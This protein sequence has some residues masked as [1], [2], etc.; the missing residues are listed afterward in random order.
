MAATETARPGQTTGR[1]AVG[2]RIPVLFIAGAARSGSTL[3]ERAIGVHDG[4]CS[5]GELQFIWQRSFGENQL[6]GCGAPFH[7][8]D[9]WRAVSY[10]AF[11][12]EPAEVDELAA[13]RLKHEVD[14]KRR[15]PSLVL[16]PP[17]R[18][19]QA[20]GAYG[21]LIERLYGSILDVAGARVVVDSSKDPRHG[22]VLSRLDCIDLH[23]VHLI[24]D[25]R[26][27]AFSW[28]RKRARP[29]IHWRAQQMTRQPVRASA[30]RWTTHNAVGEL[31]RAT[32][33]RY[34][35]L[36]YED[37]VTDPLGAVSQILAPYGCASA[38]P[39]GSPGELVLE[40]S[41]SVSGNPMR[42]DAGTLRVKLDDEWRAAMP[43]R[44][45]FAVAAV[46]WPLLARYGYHLGASA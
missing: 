36:R 46:T 29:E 9:F 4:F 16:N 40:R 31:L 10:A 22:L 44:D 19:R 26:A 39:S 7:D 8:C 28:R 38:P 25:P 6:C 18:M 34:D 15:I 32:A 12:S 11:G 2:R 5:L 13:R 27:V 33:G 14:S 1:P 45:R 37:F 43:R 23:V 3:L 21:E 35:R 24:R 20:L 30:A 17:G 41:H 42:F